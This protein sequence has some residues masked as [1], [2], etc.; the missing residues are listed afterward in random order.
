MWTIYTFLFIGMLRDVKVTSE[1]S[2]TLGS[3][4]PVAAEFRQRYRFATFWIRV[5]VV[6]WNRCSVIQITSLEMRW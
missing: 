6:Q 5:L 3:L 1:M 2:W 4:R